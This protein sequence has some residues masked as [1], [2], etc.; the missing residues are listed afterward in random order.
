MSNNLPPKH[1]SWL[2]GALLTIVSYIL[3]A[4]WSEKVSLDVA[5]TE[6]TNLLTYLVIVFA[7]PLTFAVFFLCAVIYVYIR[8]N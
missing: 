6:W 7:I 4:G 2:R 5:Q 8:D 3:A 1:I